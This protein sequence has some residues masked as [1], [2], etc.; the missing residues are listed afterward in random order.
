MEK[1]KYLLMALLTIVL[2]GA[3]LPVTTILLEH[4]FSPNLITFT[5]F[6]AAS[7]I[8]FIFFR[9]RLTEKIAAIDR[10]YFYFMGLGGTTLFFFFENSAL[11]FTTVT[12]TALITAT[13]PLFTLLTAAIFYNKKILWQNLIGLPLGL[14]GTVLLF[15]EDLQQSE[16]NLKGDLL[17]LGSVVMWI[18][19]SFSYRKVMDR[20]SPV[21]V[22]FHTFL[23]GCCFAAPLLLLDIGS[24]SGIRFNSSVLSAILFLAVLCSFLGY[25]LWTL[26][27]KNIGVKATS[28]FILLMPVVS[29]GVSIVFLSEPFTLKIFVAG[30]SIIA[31][32]WLTS[33]SRKESYF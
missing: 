31:S 30:C 12:N 18:L 9:K 20:Y 33:I 10:K 4:G 28:N 26:A 11:K 23:Y 2:W 21:T 19:Y 1:L 14:A 8:M 3:S 17:V 15:V 22:V 32:S 25:Y 27:L 5:R 13:I 7:L 6:S 24:F 29:V 16:I